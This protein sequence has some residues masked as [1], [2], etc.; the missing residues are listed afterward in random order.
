MKIDTL[1]IDRQQLASV[2]MARSLIAVFGS[3]AVT[4]CHAVRME[5]EQSS[6]GNGQK[7]KTGQSKTYK[8]FDIVKVTSKPLEDPDLRDEWIQHIKNNPAE[9]NALGL[10]RWFHN[11][12][13][14]VGQPSQ[15]PQEPTSSENPELPELPVDHF[16]YIGDKGGDVDS[17]PEDTESEQWINVSLDFDP[18]F[19]ERVGAIYFPT[20][21]EVEREHRTLEEETHVAQAGAYKCVEHAEPSGSNELAEESEVTKKEK[22]DKFLALVSGLTLQLHHKVLNLSRAILR[23]HSLPMETFAE[24]TKQA[25]KN[26]EGQEEGITMPKITAIKYVHAQELVLVDVEGSEDLPQLECTPIPA[27]ENQ[28]GD[29]NKKDLDPNFWTSPR[30]IVV[31]V[32]IGVVVIGAIVVAV[33]LLVLKKESDEE[34][35]GKAFSDDE[36]DWDDEDEESVQFTQQPEEEGC[37]ESPT[38]VQDQCE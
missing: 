11:D 21:E 22:K 7:K 33:Y 15:P 29:D 32:V 5:N 24:F 34:D 23:W 20:K 18:S 38:P 31:I 12:P 30:G 16:V 10:K 37:G 26:A 2:K 35:D 9:A 6:N 25:N 3:V 27:G 1:I 14:P 36:S 28:N 19:E 8:P 17:A 13:A 4:G